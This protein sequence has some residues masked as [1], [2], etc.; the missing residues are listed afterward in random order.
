MI[1]LWIVIVGLGKGSAL[2]ISA[3]NSFP[4]RPLPVLKQRK[5][6]PYVVL[7]IFVVLLVIVDCGVAGQI[8][9]SP[10]FRIGLTL[11]PWIISVEKFDTCGRAVIFLQQSV[12]N[13]TSWKLLPPTLVLVQSASGIFHSILIGLSKEWDQAPNISEPNGEEVTKDVVWYFFPFY[14]TVV[15]F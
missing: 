3:S 12:E 5:N 2:W 10:T 13:V 1:R 6:Y 9:F 11:P 7:C 4:V 8:R 14:S 15:R